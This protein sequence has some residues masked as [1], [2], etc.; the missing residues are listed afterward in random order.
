MEWKKFEIKG[1]LVSTKQKVFK[2][3]R[4]IGSFGNEDSDVSSP[5]QVF[6]DTP[7]V[8]VNFLTEYALEAELKKAEAL[9]YWRRSLDRPK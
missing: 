7:Y 8:P 5:S 2:L 4:L 9:E 6:A 1:K 3:F